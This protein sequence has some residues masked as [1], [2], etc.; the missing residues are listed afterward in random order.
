MGTH[1]HRF[2]EHEN[3]VN[4]WGAGRQQLAGRVGR[5]EANKRELGRPAGNVV[6]LGPPNG[7]KNR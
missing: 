1:P 2:A 3:P 7:R 4:L 6:R 5:H